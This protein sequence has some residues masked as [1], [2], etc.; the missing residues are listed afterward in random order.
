MEGYPPLKLEG[1]RTN[2]SREDVR[3]NI[4]PKVRCHQLCSGK[5]LLC[6]LEVV[7]FIAVLSMTGNHRLSC[8]A[9][10]TGGLNRSGQ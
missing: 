2:W 8:E 7:I 4:H 6:H 5:G 1:K 10:T 3:R 9:I